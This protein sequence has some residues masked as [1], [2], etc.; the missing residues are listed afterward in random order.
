LPGRE[1]GGVD[2][3]ILFHDPAL[4][5][6]SFVVMKIKHESAKVAVRNSLGTEPDCENPDTNKQRGRF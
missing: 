4:P 6:L 2:F 1:C 3:D 5:L